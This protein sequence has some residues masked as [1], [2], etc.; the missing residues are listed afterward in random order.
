MEAA[1]RDGD[2]GVRPP[3][4][5]YRQKEELQILRERYKKSMID[6]PQGDHGALLN[7]IRSIEAS[8]KEKIQTLMVEQRSAGFNLINASELDIADSEI[9][10]MSPNEAPQVK[11]ERKSVYGQ[12]NV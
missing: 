5:C 4:Y 1:I 10:E 12:L 2:R 7:R 11:S 6:E 8:I 3:I 9:E